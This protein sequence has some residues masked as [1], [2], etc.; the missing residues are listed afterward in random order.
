MTGRP[1]VMAGLD[2]SVDS[3]EGV[4]ARLDALLNAAGQGLGPLQLTDEL[5]RL[6]EHQVLS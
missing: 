4:D 2:S 5:G 3:G 6:V 1:A